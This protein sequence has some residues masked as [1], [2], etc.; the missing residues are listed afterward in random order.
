MVNDILD[1]SKLEEAGDML[2]MEYQDLTPIINLTVQSFKVIAQQKSLNITTAIESNLPKVKIN[3]DTIERVMRNLLSNAIKYTEDSGRIRVR[4]EFNPDMDAIDVS[5]QDSGIGISQEHLDKIFDR[6]FRVEN[7]VHTVKGTGL[8][9]HL[10]KT[11]I[12]THHHGEVFVSSEPGVGST[13]GFRLFLS[14]KE[15]NDEFEIV[16]HPSNSSILAD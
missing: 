4:A 12:E 8:G 14:E 2:E 6:F 16:G 9:L 11:A 13:F 5:V 10:V 7:E 15:D 1:F 3:S